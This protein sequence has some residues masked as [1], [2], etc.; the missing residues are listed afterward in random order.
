MNLGIEYV[1]Q[2]LAPV[3]RS[4]S[5]FYYQVVAVAE[6]KSYVAQILLSAYKNG[7]LQLSN[8]DWTRYAFYLFNKSINLIFASWNG[9]ENSET[10]TTTNNAYFDGASNDYDE[11]DYDD[12]AYAGSDEGQSE[13]ATLQE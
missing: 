13:I 1:E 4:R 9:G 11:D 8:R 5:G 10:M 7:G 2:T 3:R 6:C 12:D